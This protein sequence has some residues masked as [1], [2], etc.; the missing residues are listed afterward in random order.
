MLPSK[1]GT[2]VDALRT[3]GISFFATIFRDKVAG[4]LNRRYLYR[5]GAFICRSCEATADGAVAH[6]ML[7]S[8]PPYT[9]LFRRL[10]QS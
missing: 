6:T 7:D 3:Y 4:R 10:S 5:G 2:G 1:S 9:C 8:S